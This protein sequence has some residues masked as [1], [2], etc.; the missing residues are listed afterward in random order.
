MEYDIWSSDF[1]TVEVMTVGL[2]DLRGDKWK[3]YLQEVSS[4]VFYYE[5]RDTIY[6]GAVQRQ[7]Q[8]RRV[9]VSVLHG[10]WV[11]SWNVTRNQRWFACHTNKHM[12]LLQIERQ[13]R[14][15]HSPNTLH[16]P[17]LRLV[18]PTPNT[19]TICKASRRLLHRRRRQI[20]Q[21]WLT[22]TLK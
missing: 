20:S 12:H 19:F 16:Y 5:D 21:L 22:A 14:A 9:L 18:V 1:S 13:L 2:L 7:R 4:D 15:I 6:K 10:R 11:L 17:I 3:S 8:R